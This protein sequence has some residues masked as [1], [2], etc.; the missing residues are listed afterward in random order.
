MSVRQLAWRALYELLAARVQRPEWAFMN[1][2]YL[3]QPPADR[4]VLDAADEPDR[5]CIQLYDHV[6][7]GTD[8]RGA[9]VLE[10]GCGRG[11]GASFIARYRAPRATIGLDLSRRAVA[12]CR[13]HRRAPGLSFVEGDALALPFPDDAFDAVVNVESSHCYSSMDDFLA[14]VHRVLRPGGSLLFADLR[15]AR[16]MAALRRRLGEGPLE[17]VDLDDI[18]ADV[19]GALDLD[20]DRRRALMEAWI[21]RRFHRAFAPFAGFRGTETFAKL[22]RREIQYVSARLVKAADAGAA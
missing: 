4:P 19:R 21:P 6:L 13:R 9:D 18:T 1:Y 5:L 3:V 16:E 20:D 10:V 12:L 7:T 8:L 11:G 14:E 22:E 17:L 15:P 2:G